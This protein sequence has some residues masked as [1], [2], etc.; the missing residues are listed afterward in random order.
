VKIW[1]IYHSGGWKSAV[2][3]EYLDFKGDQAQASGRL[4]HINARDG[5]LLMPGW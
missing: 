2:V 3:G 4:L 1:I 5:S